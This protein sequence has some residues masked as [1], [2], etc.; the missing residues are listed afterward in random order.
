[1]WC[2]LQLRALAGLRLLHLHDHLGFVEHGLRGGEDLRARL[3]VGR[4]RGAEAHAGVRLDHHVMAGADQL[5][6]ALRCE[7]HAVFLRL[8][9]F[10]NANAHAALP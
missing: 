10:R 7:T 9:L 3:D 5:A 6:N 2:G 4:V 8:D 1:V